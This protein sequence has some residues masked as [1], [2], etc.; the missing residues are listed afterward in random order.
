VNS[1]RAAVAALAVAVGGPAAAE[2]CAVHVVSE[3]AGAEVY[4]DGLRVGKT[5]LLHVHGREA[6]VR[7]RIVKEGFKP[8]ENDVDIPL[9]AIAGLTVKLVR[10]DPRS[11]GSRRRRSRGGAGA[12][13]PIGNILKP[14]T[15]GG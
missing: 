15:P 2:F 10:A 1:I 6:R 12:M 8:W 7:V 13:F 11:R 14:A 5:P 3:P 9:N 4:V